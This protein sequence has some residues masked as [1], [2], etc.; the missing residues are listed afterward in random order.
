M[1]VFRIAF[2]DTRRL[3]KDKQIYFW[4]IAFPMLFVFLFGS[5]VKFRSNEKTWVPVIDLDKHELATLFIDRLKDEQFNIDIRQPS[6]EHNLQYW[7]RAIIIPATFSS[8]ILAG[9]RADITFT[10]GQG[11][12]D[13]TLLVQ[14]RVVR[15]IAEFTGAIASVDIIGKP[16]SE[17]L[18]QQ[19]IGELDQP[20][21]VLIEKHE[22]SALRPP[23]AGFSFTLPSY[24]VMFVLMNSIMMGGITLATERAL[25]QY[26]RLAV[27]PLSPLQII[28]GKI[29]GRF[30]FPLIQSV[31]MLGFGYFLFGVPMGDHPWVLIPVV[32]CLSFCCGSIGLLFGALC[33][34]EQQVNSFGML[35]AMLL[36]AL[37]GCWWPMEV[38]PDFVKT[39]AMIT[40][41]FWG[42]Q[43]LHDV[44]SFGKSL[45]AVLPECA[46]LIGFSILFTAIAV[47]FLKP[48]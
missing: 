18:K 26:T 44:M 3:F 10:K 1:N 15:T 16:W 20:K 42:L 39:I 29:V 4:M 40:P 2:W 37:G 33:K 19:L 45:P 35:A 31:L 13:H 5:I 38:N 22:H 43:G 47:P 30:Y 23:P 14:S 9:N 24:L 11:N 12:T 41:A 48:E 32:F 46:A 27:A 6:D 25:H 36:S 34:T 7:S 21:R 17:T 28:L 8:D